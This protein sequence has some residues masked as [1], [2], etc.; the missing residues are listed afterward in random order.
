MHDNRLMKTAFYAVFV[1]LLDLPLS[2]SAADEPGHIYSTPEAWR[3][4]VPEK[5]HRRPEYAFVETDPELPN[6][7]LIGD[8][9]SMSYTVGVREELAGI[10]NV[11][12]APDNCRSTRQT[13][14]AIETYLGQVRWD[15]IH[16]NWGIHDLTH[17][18][19]SG[20]TAPPPEGKPQV[21]LDQYRDNIRKL[22]QR[23]RKTDARLIWASTTPVGRKAEAQGFRRNSDVIAYNDAASELLKV[24][25]L[26][27]NDLYSL[28][29][30]QAEQWLSDGVHFTPYGQTVLAKAVAQTIQDSLE[31]EKQTSS[32]EL[33]PTPT[34]PVNPAR[35]SPDQ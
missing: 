14:D 7:L 1:L 19:V 3:R 33:S 31:D 2:V 25:N 32:K 5:Y 26:K 20:K 30:P 27:T 8:S 11:Y 10:A 18:N 28:V 13:L 12:R 16:F 35:A 15:V 23:L 17:L 34:S 24:E 4:A 21:P 22:L 6:V 29:K 9:V